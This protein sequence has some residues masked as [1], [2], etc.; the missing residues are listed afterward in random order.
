[1]YQNVSNNVFL[2]WFNF[3]AKIPSRSG[4]CVWGECQKYSP[5]SPSLSKDEGLREIGHRI[6]IGNL[7]WGVNSVTVSKLIHYDS[8]LQN[9]ANIL[10]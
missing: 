1:M 2:Q 4:A 3:Q 9:A 8:L 7:I 5:S 10:I 6:I